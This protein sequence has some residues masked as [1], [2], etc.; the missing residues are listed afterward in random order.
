M[1]SRPDT[2]LLYRVAQVNYVSYVRGALFCNILIFLLDKKIVGNKWEIAC[3]FIECQ[4]II[5]TVSRLCFPIVPRSQI[6]ISRSR[7]FNPTILKLRLDL[8]LTHTMD[9]LCE[10]WRLMEIDRMCVYVR[11]ND[12]FRRNVNVTGYFDIEIECLLDLD[13]DILCSY[14]VTPCYIFSNVKWH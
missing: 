14:F 1:D 11:V 8:S 2:F 5:W 13:R 9:T 6:I 3:Q 10:T 7:C 12:R 4:C